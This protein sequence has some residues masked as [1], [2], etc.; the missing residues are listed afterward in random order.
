MVSNFHTH[1]AHCDGTGSC[2]DYVLYAKEQGL[3]SLGFSSHAPLPFPCR[4]SLPE[5]HLADYL[6]EI[7]HLQINHEIELYKGLEVDYIPHVTGP[8]K[9][10]HL[11]D[12]TI[13]S[14]HFVD[15]L[16]DGTPWE[17]DG[18]HAVFSMGLDQIF[19]NNMRDVIHRYF[20]ITREMVESDCPDIIG[21][22]DKIKIQN[23]HSPY[24]SET[25]SWYWSEVKATLDHISRHGSIVEVN[26]RGL[27]Q[28]K[29]VEP[30][31]GLKALTYMHQKGIPITLNSDAHHPNQLAKGFFATVKELY[32]IGFRELHILQR[33]TWRPIPLTLYG[34][35][36]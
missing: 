14:V 32:R 29:T 3:V 23:H 33:G 4:W 34:V 16:P 15:Y 20:Q 31:P 10:K 8:K 1:T 27:Y 25:E 19:N 28:G 36:C 9:F 11:L 12:Y 22:L 30:Y 17:I 13:G 26:T 6:D 2:I 24:F 7:T 18:P 5:N 35:A 21:H